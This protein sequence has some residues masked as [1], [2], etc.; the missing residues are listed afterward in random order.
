MSI[1]EKTPIYQTICVFPC[2]STFRQWVFPPQNSW[3]FCLLGEHVKH[4]HEFCFEKPHRQRAVI[5]ECLNHRL[6]VLVRTF[7]LL[8][9]IV[10]PKIKMVIILSPLLHY[11]AVW[12]LNKIRYFKKCW[13]PSCL[14]YFWT[15]KTTFWEYQSQWFLCFTEERQ[16]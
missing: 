6:A 3:T 2:M 12:L 16:S 5:L 10:H 13:E 11:K 4:P 14:D 7:S 9:G 8:K 15:K 1:V